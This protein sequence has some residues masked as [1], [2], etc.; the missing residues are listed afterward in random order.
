[1]TPPLIHLTCNGQTYNVQSAKDRMPEQNV[2]HRLQKIQLHHITYSVYH[3]VE[4]YDSGWK[5]MTP[6]NLLSLQSQNVSLH[7][8][9]LSGR[10]GPGSKLSL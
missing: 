2:K 7:F 6:G 5:V 9:Y 8:C 1:M 4:S 10:V 3:I